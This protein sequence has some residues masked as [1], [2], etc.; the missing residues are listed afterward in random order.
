M[1][2][3]AQACK[4]STSLVDGKD[5]IAISLGWDESSIVSK[6]A[7]TKCSHQTYQGMVVGFKHKQMFGS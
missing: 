1:P 5:D 3:T 4:T 6:Q 7:Q 2:N